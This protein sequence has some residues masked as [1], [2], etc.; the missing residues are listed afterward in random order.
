MKRVRFLALLAAAAALAIGCSSK[1]ETAKT[2]ETQSTEVAQEAPSADVAQE[3]PSADD[4]QEAPSTSTEAT[5]EAE[6]QTTYGKAVDAA[7]A[8]DETKAVLA[9]LANPEYGIDPVCKMAID[10]SYTAEIDGK[11][12]GFCSETCENEARAHPEKYLMVASLGQ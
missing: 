4:A 3:A 1:Q 9:K 6:P 2:D 7:K 8:V 12:Y 5:Q 11:L 10:G